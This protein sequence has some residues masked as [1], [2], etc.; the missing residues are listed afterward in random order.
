MHEVEVM[1]KIC[2]SPNCKLYDLIEIIPDKDV[3]SE[4]TNNG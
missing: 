4:G 3:F 2:S 1:V